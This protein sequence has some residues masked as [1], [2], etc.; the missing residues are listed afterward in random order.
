[1]SR[2]ARPAPSRS[3]SDPG[4]IRVRSE[5]DPSQIRDQ[6]HRAG[7]EA[8]DGVED[9]DGGTVLFAKIYMHML[10]MYFFAKIYMHIGQ[11]DIDGV[12]ADTD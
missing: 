10:H 6:Y 4:Q 2:A 5:S 3:E 1:M 11:S 7:G 9:G 12:A 8:D